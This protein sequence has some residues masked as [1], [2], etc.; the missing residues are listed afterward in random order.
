MPADSRVQLIAQ[1]L[2][3][4]S[5]RRQQGDDLVEVVGQ[6]E[7]LG[8]DDH[9]KSPHELPAVGE[10]RID[11]ALQ[12]AVVFAATRVRRELR[13]SGYA[14]TSGRCASRPSVAATRAPA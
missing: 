5:T 2:T 13:H 1:T 3:R 8:R 12:L 11:D 4:V 7:R 10:H 9:V 6:V 14:S